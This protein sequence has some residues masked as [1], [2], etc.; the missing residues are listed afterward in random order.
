MFCCIY[1]RNYLNIN[2]NQM[3]CFSLSSSVAS[4][5]C[6]R[7]KR[8]D[9]RLKRF[10]FPF[11]PYTFHIHFD[12]R[13]FLPSQ[14]PFLTLPFVAFHAPIRYFL[15]NIRKRNKSVSKSCRFSDK[16]SR[17]RIIH[18]IFLLNILARSSSSPSLL[19]F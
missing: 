6:S 12:V 9:D 4:I 5:R 18:S 19:P 3:T 10:R 15:E 2:I 16:M 17:L 8:Q 1:K 13:Y 7:T 14:K 11:S